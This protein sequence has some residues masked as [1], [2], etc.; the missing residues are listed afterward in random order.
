MNEPD[1]S[2]VPA[3][4]LQPALQP[5]IVKLFLENQSSEISLRE[6]ETF[7]KSKELDVREKEI[8][9]AHEYSLK[10]L[11][12]QAADRIDNR[13]K[14]SSDI[15]VILLFLSFIALVIAFLIIYALHEGQT[16]LV[17]EC[18]KAAVFIITGG[19][20]GYGLKSIKHGEARK[21]DEDD[22]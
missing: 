20:G 5:E 16:Q 9:K 11:E 19:V 13:Q 22:E 17:L 3:P 15:K 14:F 10:S 7:I 4:P 18:V 2:I 12:A 6:K 1:G 21:K 8:D